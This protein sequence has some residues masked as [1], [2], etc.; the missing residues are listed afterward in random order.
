ME[1]WRK[2]DEGRRERIRDSRRGGTRESENVV[3]ECEAMAEDEL[4]LESGSGTGPQ[5]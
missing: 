4:W 1:A 2:N 3:W 5:D